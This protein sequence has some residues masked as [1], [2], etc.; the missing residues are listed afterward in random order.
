MFNLVKNS[1]QYQGQRN[2]GK[3]FLT[4]KESL[5]IYSVIS[6]SS[7]NGCDVHEH[8]MSGRGSRVG[9]GVSKC[10]E[11]QWSVQVCSRGGLGLRMTMVKQN[12]RHIIM[13]SYVY[14]L[15]F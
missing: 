1:I 14:K 11:W 4:H 8:K 10:P 13:H 7:V 6:E 5:F 2:N 15:L 3:Y 12:M 9:S